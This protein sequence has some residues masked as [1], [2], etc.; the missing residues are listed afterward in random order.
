M[1]NEHIASDGDRPNFDTSDATGGVPDAIRDALLTKVH[2]LEDD[3]SA[4]GEAIQAAD[5]AA[6]Q[7]KFATAAIE[8]VVALAS[9]VIGGALTK[10][11]WN[12]GVGIEQASRG[13]GSQLV[14]AVLS[15][16]ASGNQT[17]DL[18]KSILARRG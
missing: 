5:D 3:I 6:E 10:S 16:G 14:S 17:V 12:S 15:G 2:E 7:L 11:G 13:L 18:V 8:K 1:G 4:I 9:T